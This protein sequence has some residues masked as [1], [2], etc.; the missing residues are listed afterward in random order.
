[1][2]TGICWLTVA[3]S[4]LAVLVL[5]FLFHRRWFKFDRSST[6]FMKPL[7]PAC[8]AAIRLESLGAIA[9]HAGRVI[10]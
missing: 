6:A 1:M 7:N 5:P 10:R 2:L 9:L 3:L 4:N 8:W